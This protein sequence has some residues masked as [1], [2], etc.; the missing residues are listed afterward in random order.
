VPDVSASMGLAWWNTRL[1]PQ[2]GDP[3]SSHVRD[4]ASE[5]VS[6]LMDHLGVHCL[7]LGEVTE[8]DVQFLVK[9]VTSPRVRYWP[10][11]VT[12]GSDRL[13]LGLLYDASVIGVLGSD[14][15]LA[16]AADRTFRT[17]RAF[18]LRVAQADRSIHLVLS[19][20]NSRQ[21]LARGSPPR[22]KL[23]ID[24]RRIA[25]E[26]GEMYE[27]DPLLILMGDYND[28]PFDEPLTDWLRASRDREL[29]RKKR[30]MFYNPFWRKL[31]EAMPHTADAYGAGTTGTCFDKQGVDTHWRT[32]DQMIFSRAFLCDSEWELREDLVEIVDLSGLGAHGP[33]LSAHFDH[34]PIIGAVQRTQ[35]GG[36]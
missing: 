5:V 25:D 9:Q 17:G 31:G 2:R 10:T 4:L 21:R 8:S 13:R 3:A 14:D 29:V 32:F 19:H 34:Y 24:L 35:R 30:G 7:G 16:A 22:I 26:L 20:W 15:Y 33:E 1:S 27:E 12:A 18:E 28:E 11:A 36:L 23:G 6:W